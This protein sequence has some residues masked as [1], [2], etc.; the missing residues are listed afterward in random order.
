LRA[1]FGAGYRAG[2]DYDAFPV[3]SLAVRRVPTLAIIVACLTGAAS[4][5]HA[6]APGPALPGTLGTQVELFLPTADGGGVR[7]ADLRGRPV[8]VHFVTTW[9]M[10]AQVDLDELRRVRTSYPQVVLLEVALDPQR[11]VV[12]PWVRAAGIDWAVAL[13]VP[14]LTAGET[15]FGLVKVVPTTFVVD[16]RGRIAWRRVEGLRRGELEAVLHSLEG[17]GQGP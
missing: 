14:E 15:A 5:G 13:P 7:F 10:A 12:V 1:Y 17:R 2:G 8:I 3:S 9:S 16:A 11:R 6:A 4:C